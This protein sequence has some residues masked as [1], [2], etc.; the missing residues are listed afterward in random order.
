MSYKLFLDDVRNPAD[1]KWIELPLGPWVIVRNFLDFKV[2]VSSRGLPEHVSFDHDLAEEHYN[3][4]LW[5]KSKLTDYAKLENATG[6]DCA[7]WLTEHCRTF[8]LD[9][10]S[11]TVHSMNPVGRARIT[12]A[13]EHYK[14]YCKSTIK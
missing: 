1:V 6:Y 14:S 8:E 3:P 9:L 10:P 5:A 13:L 12:A 7:V 2:V 11:Y 4:A